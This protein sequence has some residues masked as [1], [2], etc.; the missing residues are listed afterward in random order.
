[1]NVLT[2]T[3]VNIDWRQYDKDV[4]DLADKIHKAD[5]GLSC[6]CPIPRGGCPIGVHLSHLLKIPM[7]SSPHGKTLIVDDVSD[8]GKTL[9]EWHGKSGIYT[10]TLYWKEGALVM[11]NF[12]VRGYEKSQWIVYPWEV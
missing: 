6:I 7:E 3:N 9:L 12:T 8:T 4:R 1:M 10:A 2:S 5:L 11:P